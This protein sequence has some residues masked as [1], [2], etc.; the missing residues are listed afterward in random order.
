M[1]MK[2]STQSINARSHLKQ[3]HALGMF[4]CFLRRLSRGGMVTVLCAM[5]FLSGCGGNGGYSVTNPVGEISMPD[6]IAMSYSNLNG[7]KFGEHFPVGDNEILEFQVAVQTESGSLSIY[8]TDDNNND[9][10]VYSA[11]DIPTSEFEFT[12]DEPGQY[13]LWLEAEDHKGGYTITV[14]WKQKP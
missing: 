11:K 3:G 7:T 12:L 1:D 4:F 14:V 8:L 2:Q 6:Q 9:M 13:T 10:T 5:L